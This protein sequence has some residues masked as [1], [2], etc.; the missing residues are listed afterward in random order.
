MTFNL[1]R[2]G[3]AASVT[4]IGDS[5]LAQVYA[6][7]GVDPE[8]SEVVTDFEGYGGM[9]DSEAAVCARTIGHY[10]IVVEMNGYR[11]SLLST[12]KDGRTNGS[13]CGNVFWNFDDEFLDALFVDTEGA[14]C[15]VRPKFD[16]DPDPLPPDLLSLSEEL[17][18]AS[19]S[20]HQS[21]GDKDIIG[22]QNSL[23][24]ILGRMIETFT[25][26]EFPADLLDVAETGLRPNV[27]THL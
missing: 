26:L 22:S 6:A 17:A 25:G 21:A 10:V 2:L 15:L 19:E 11:G 18:R 4:V 23:V 14:T 1:S 12:L 8:T 27:G 3:D 7:F 9:D 16:P 20:Y 5:S 13:R 24:D